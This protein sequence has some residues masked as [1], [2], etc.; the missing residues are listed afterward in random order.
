MMST[1]PMT[2]SPDSAEFLSRLLDVLER[3]VVPLTRESVRAG[4]KV[5]GADQKTAHV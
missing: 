4:N 2:P 5:F 3:D 1:T